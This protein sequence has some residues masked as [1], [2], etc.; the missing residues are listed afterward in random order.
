MRRR[1]TNII[2]GGL[3][4][5]VLFATYA[6]AQ[7]GE[8]VAAEYGEGGHRVDVTPQ[9]RRY[10]HDGTLRFKVSNEDLAVRGRSVSVILRRERD[11]NLCEQHEDAF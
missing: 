8:L 11:S 4:C 5:M 6:A 3:A 1:R 7:G 9:V 10:L 2:L